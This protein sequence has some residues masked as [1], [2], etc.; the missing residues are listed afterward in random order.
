L[1]HLRDIPTLMTV[2]DLIFERLPQHHKFK[3]RAFLKGAMPMFC[4][5]A[6]AIITISQATKRDLIEL[7]GLDEG[8]I[9]VIYEA[10][11]A[12]FEPQND[13]EIERVTERYDLPPRY[14]VTVGT[15]EPRKNLS[16]LADA[17]G[18][19]IDEGL[20]GGLVVVGS[21]GWLYEGFF[22]H[23]G[24]LPWRNEIIF[25]GYVDDADLPAVYAGAALTV[26]PSLYEGFGLPLLEAMASGSPVCCSNVSSMPE[27]GGDAVM[28]FDPSDTEAMTA[29]MRQVLLDESLAASMRGRGF[30]R[31]GQFTWEHTARETL[32]LYERVLAN[33]G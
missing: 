13:A 11:D 9:S 14:I 30:A 7:Y 12:R 21:K 28:P 6:D 2:H 24:T 4:K 23:V 27:I 5:R 26:Q 15:I 31:A 8:K 22:A 3:N 10:A 16:R 19:L 33:G 18:P 29:A 32:A 1:P 25:P 20:I 17:C